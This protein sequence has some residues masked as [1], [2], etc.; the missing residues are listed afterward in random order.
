MTTTK[1]DTIETTLNQADPNE[2]PD[3]FRKMKLGQASTPR[4]VTFTGLASSAVQDITTA[5]AFAAAVAVPPFPAGTTRLPAIG[6]VTAL[7][8]TAGTVLGARVIIDSGGTP[9][10]SATGIGGAPG[11]SAALSDNG[12]TLTFE[13]VITAMVLEY[14]PRP[15]TGDENTPTDLTANFA[16]T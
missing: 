2:L 6:T 7:R 3:A 14:I 13:A 8:V 16:R 12:K 11:G 10:A 15:S 1:A 9:A 5:A 4:K